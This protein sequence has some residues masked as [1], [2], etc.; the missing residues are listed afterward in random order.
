MNTHLYPANISGN[1]LQHTLRTHAQWLGSKYGT[2]H[3]NNPWNRTTHKSTTVKRC[4][5]IDMMMEIL[6]ADVAISPNTTTLYE[7]STQTHFQRNENDRIFG[8]KCE[9]LNTQNTHTHTD[10]H[11]TCTTTHWAHKDV[12]WKC[13][14]EGWWSSIKE[15][16]WSMVK[17]DGWRICW[18][19]GQRKLQSIYTEFEGEKTHISLSR[20][21]KDNLTDTSSLCGTLLS[22]PS[23]KKNIGASLKCTWINMHK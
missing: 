16:Y 20:W 9:L 19:G 22:H 11:N 14:N 3:L 7:T 17:V 8:Y 13:V 6:K 1:K 10:A 18:V 5:L 12:C 15:K 21:R 4:A 23:L 2:N